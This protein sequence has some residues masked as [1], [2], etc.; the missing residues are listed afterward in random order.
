MRVLSHRCLLPAVLIASLMACKGDARE[1]RA[2]D[3][4]ERPP[5]DSQ[6]SAP[7]GD[8]GTPDKPDESS[9]PSLRFTA[10]EDGA[11]V[12]N[13]V[14]FEFESRDVHRAILEVDDVPVTLSDFD[15]ERR[16][17]VSDTSDPDTPHTAVLI[18]Y[19]E[20]GETIARASLS[21]QISPDRN[22]ELVGSF[23]NSFYYLPG[24][25]SLYGGEP[26]KI[27]TM[28]CEVIATVPMAFVR[29]TCLQGSGRLDPDGVV[30]LAGRCDCGVPCPGGPKRCFTVLDPETYPWGAG[31]DLKPTMPLRTWAVDT[32]VLPSDALVFAEEW[33]GLWIPRVG[34]IGG[35]SH[36]GCFVAQDVG[37]GIDG[38]QVDIFTGSREMWKTLE[39]I[40]PT[41]SEMT[42]YLDAPQCEESPAAELAD[43]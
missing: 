28:D 38:Y 16:T 33:D 3:A 25:E 35:F 18:G 15:P 2:D 9:G 1:A 13:P 19:D 30:S 22:S 21:F 4:P 17:Q 40:Y 36:D 24:E 41:R 29:E 11:S 12:P 43:R 5:V 26:A 37:G 39:G 8:A 14:T 42:V 23:W 34:D 27:R 20:S 6:E 10:P 31:P 32:R 7:V